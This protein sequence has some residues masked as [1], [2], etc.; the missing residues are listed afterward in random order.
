MTNTPPLATTRP[1]TSISPFAELVTAI[2]SGEKARIGEWTISDARRQFDA[3]G[4]TY[5]ATASNAVYTSGAD[6]ITEVGVSPSET[7]NLLGN[8]VDLTVT[9]SGKMTPRTFEGLVFQVEPRMH[10]GR[11]QDR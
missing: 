5:I 1:S 8:R 7:E 11:T 10:A 2:E 6:V 3:P 9:I 4:N